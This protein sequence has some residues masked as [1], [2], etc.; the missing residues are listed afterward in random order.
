MARSAGYWSAIYMGRGTREFSDAQLLCYLA[1][2]RHMSLAFDE[3]RALGTLQEGSDV[4]LAELRQ[5]G[6][7]LR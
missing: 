6:H 4:L 1:I 3:A 7:R 5:R 2:T